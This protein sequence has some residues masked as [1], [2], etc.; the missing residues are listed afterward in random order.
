MKKDLDK[1]FLWLSIFIHVFIL[2]VISVFNSNS[3]IKRPFLVFGAYSKKP[4]HAYF[5][6]LKAPPNISSI[7]TRSRISSVKNLNN[8]VKVADKKTP[9]KK[10][11]EEKKKSRCEIESK[12]KLVAENI[13][14]R[15]QPKKD[16]EPEKLATKKE[17]AL[18]KVKKEELEENEIQ[19]A[20][21]NEP[22]NF[23]LFGD[24]DPEML[25]YYESIQ[26]EVCKIWKPPLGA[27]KGTECTVSF[28]LDKNGNVKEFNIVTPSKMLIYDLSVVKVAKEFKFDECLYGKTFCITFRQ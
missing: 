23:N 24:R 4:T 3:R 11:I 9:A 25:K 16:K 26:K 6:P 2:I 20:E 7:Q 8:K 10:I 5:H 28:V 13:S 1:R 18:E 14:A 17:Q 19:V 15:K 12:K 21:N 27:S 22:L